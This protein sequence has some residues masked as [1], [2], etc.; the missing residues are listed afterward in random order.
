MKTTINNLTIEM[1]NGTIK[2]ND[3]VVSF[4]ATKSLYLEIVKDCSNFGKWYQYGIT[5]K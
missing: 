2:I 1:I 4:R 3:N 5:L